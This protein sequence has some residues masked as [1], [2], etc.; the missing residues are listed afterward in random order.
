M[1]RYRYN[2][3]NNYQELRQYVKIVKAGKSLDV[4][5]KI[6][7]QR[8]IKRQFNYLSSANA[9]EPELY[10]DDFV[11]QFGVLLSQEQLDKFAN[12]IPN[13]SI[14]SYCPY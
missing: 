5:Q 1:G 14:S 10:R 6:N 2:G 4:E 13:N 3:D 11:H 9:S 7:A 8:I 12:E